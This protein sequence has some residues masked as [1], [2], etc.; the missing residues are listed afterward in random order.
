MLLPTLWEF[1]CMEP[2]HKCWLLAFSLLPSLPSFLYLFF[3]ASKNSKFPTS[4]SQLTRLISL[5]YPLHP[6]GEILPVPWEIKEKRQWKGHCITTRVKYIV[7]MHLSFHRNNTL[8]IPKYFFITFNNLL[9][10]HFGCLTEVGK[11][12]LFVD[13][14]RNQGWEQWQILVQ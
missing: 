8:T 5:F 4:P 9:L 10:H 14:T 13:K 12:S 7:C 6:L 2:I 11:L 3:P 1:S